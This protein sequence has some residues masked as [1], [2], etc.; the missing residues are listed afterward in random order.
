MVTATTPMGEVPQRGGTSWISS[1]V[2][3]DPALI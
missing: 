1:C 3:C 2:P